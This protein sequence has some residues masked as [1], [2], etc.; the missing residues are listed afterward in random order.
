MTDTQASRR[1]GHEHIT[2]KKPSIWRGV[3]DCL[4][5]GREMT[6]EE[7]AMF[8]GIGLNNVR[9]R[10]T[11]LKAVGKVETNGRKESPNTGVKT[12]IWRIVKDEICSVE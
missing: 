3:L 7:I 4:A 6:A 9:S 5:D 2:P 11:E 8:T 1:D 12:S 10:L